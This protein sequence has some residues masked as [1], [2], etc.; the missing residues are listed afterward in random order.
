MHIYIDIYIYVMQ[1]HIFTH[2]YANVYMS[3]Y[4]YINTYI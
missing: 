1:I 2:E 3:T 4:I